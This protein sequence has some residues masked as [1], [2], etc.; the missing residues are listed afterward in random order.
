MFAKSLIVVLCL[1]AYAQAKPPRSEFNVPGGCV[2]I[3]ETVGGK[4]K[5]TMRC[6]Y[7]ADQIA[8][9]RQGRGAKS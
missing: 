5:E 4:V 1:A 7:N 6:E 3:V 9:M 2:L 8:R